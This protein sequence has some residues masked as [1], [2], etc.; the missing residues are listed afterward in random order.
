MEKEQEEK[1]I[2]LEEKFKF[3]C[4][5]IDNISIVIKESFADIKSHYMPICLCDEKHKK[6]IENIDSNN[7]EIKSLK[8]TVYCMATG[9]IAQF[10]GILIMVIFKL[11]K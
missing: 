4:E 10:V 11:W 1:I 7:K 8:N 6:N 3:I 2:R 9:C 5:K